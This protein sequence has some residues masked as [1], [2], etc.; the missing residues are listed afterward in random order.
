MSNVNAATYLRT[1]LLTYLLLHN[2]LITDTNT[3]GK[4]C[5]YAVCEIG[6]VLSPDAVQHTQRC[7][8]RRL[9]H[10]CIAADSYM[11]HWRCYWHK[12]IEVSDHA[13]LCSSLQSQDRAE[14][15]NNIQQPFTNSATWVLKKF[16]LIKCLVLLQI[17]GP[18]LHEW[19]RSF[20]MHMVT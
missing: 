6:K 2:K 17:T 5:S 1:H 20:S 3:T 9:Q 13:H 19:I 11:C 14:S 15:N 10:S 18:H 8:W 12:G 4:V 7:Q 16:W